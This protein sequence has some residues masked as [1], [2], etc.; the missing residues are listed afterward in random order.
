MY[1]DGILFRSL[2]ESWYPTMLEITIMMCNF[3]VKIRRSTDIFP[4]SLIECFLKAVMIYV[5]A[6]LDISKTCIERKSQ[7][8]LNIKRPFQLLYVLF[9]HLSVS[10]DNCFP[11]SPNPK[12]INAFTHNLW[13]D[14]R[15]T[16]LYY[17][18]KRNIS[19][20]KRPIPYTGPKPSWPIKTL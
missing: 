20:L 12:H 7:L 13:N 15:Q 9:S 19:K 5:A 3:E 10:P 17:L 4:L 2:L 14:K 6:S 16:S 11:Q 1:L 18:G 8:I